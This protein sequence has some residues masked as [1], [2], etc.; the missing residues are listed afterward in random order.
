MLQ[1]FTGVP[2]VEKAQRNRCQTSPSKNSDNK[3]NKTKPSLGKPDGVW[4]RQPMT[5]RL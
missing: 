5:L 1:V 2:K 3:A 4:Q